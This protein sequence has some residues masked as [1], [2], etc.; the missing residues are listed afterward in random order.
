[1]TLYTVLY[2]QIVKGYHATASQAVLHTSICVA[3]VAV[4]KLTIGSF[5]LIYI[6]VLVR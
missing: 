4:D 5:F 3:V 2:P 6:R 1:M